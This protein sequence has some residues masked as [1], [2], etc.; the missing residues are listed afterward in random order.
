MYMCV[1]VR[2]REPDSRLFHCAALG[3]LP[4]IMPGH[5][6]FLTYL[7]FLRKEISDVDY[8]A[9]IELTIEEEGGE[10]KACSSGGTYVHSM[11]G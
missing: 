5:V 2:E 7:F 3:S 9:I 8:A 6:L 10:K 4:R 11:T 1:C